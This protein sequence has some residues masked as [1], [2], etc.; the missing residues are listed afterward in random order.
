[1]TEDS[2][3]REKLVRLFTRQYCVEALLDLLQGAVGEH[4]AR[5]LG[6]VRGGQ[7]EGAKVVTH[8]GQQQLVGPHH[9]PVSG[10]DDTVGG[11]AAVRQVVRPKGPHHIVVSENKHIQPECSNYVNKICVILQSL[12]FVQ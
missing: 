10:D 11:K 9:L 6:P 2:K 5:L 7:H 12:C 4:K 1:M 8:G 3:H